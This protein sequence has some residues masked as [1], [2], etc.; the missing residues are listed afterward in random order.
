MAPKTGPQQRT[1]DGFMTKLSPEEWALEQ[2]KR[3]IAYEAAP[4][5]EFVAEPSVQVVASPCVRIVP[6]KRG[7]G[8][9]R[10]PRTLVPQQTLNDI[11]IG[12]QDQLLG[13]QGTNGTNGTLGTDGTGKSTGTDVKK[14]SPSISPPSVGKRKTNWMHPALF[15]RIYRC[16]IVWNLLEVNF[17]VA[18]AP[19]DGEVEKQ[20]QISG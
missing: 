15:I 5:V 20:L 2:E 18:H 7:P 14:K 4:S 10:L 17:N 12:S 6:E 11:I 16:D 8:R 13:T 3:R 1:L 19:Q 9:P